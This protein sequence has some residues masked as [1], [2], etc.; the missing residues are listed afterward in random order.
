MKVF[1]EKKT[2][3]VPSLPTNRKAVS[4]NLLFSWTHFRTT[5]LRQIK[6]A[7]SPLTKSRD[8]TVQAMGRV[9]GA[10]LDIT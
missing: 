4:V 5:I 3:Q 7:D 2:G 8:T 9:L 6:T 10:F 1:T